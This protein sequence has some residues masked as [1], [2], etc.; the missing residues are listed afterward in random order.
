[1]WLIFPWFSTYLIQKRPSATKTSRSLNCLSNL[2]K[3]NIPGEWYIRERYLYLLS[4][5]SSVHSRLKMGT[6]WIVFVLIL[7]S[8]G[9][10]LSF[11]YYLL[12][13]LHKDILSTL[14]KLLWICELLPAYTALKEQRSITDTHQLQ[15][16]LLSIPGVLGET[17]E[18]KLLTS[19]L[20]KYDINAR[21]VMDPTKAIRVDM[22]VNLMQII[23]LVS[24]D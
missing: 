18:Y 15:V 5:V 6:L 19:L 9:R 2:F 7:Y 20:S 21:P 8:I 22:E 24:P 11:S 17:P 10:C 12:L 1:M 14:I 3:Q 13:K 23:D 4:S 16:F